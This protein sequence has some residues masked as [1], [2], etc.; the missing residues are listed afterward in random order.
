[1]MSFSKVFQKSFKVVYHGQIT[2]QTSTL[3]GICIFKG[4]NPIL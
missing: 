1:M 4:S 2:I 3:P